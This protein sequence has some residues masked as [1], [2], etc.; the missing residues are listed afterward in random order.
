MRLARRAGCREEGGAPLTT[1]STSLIHCVWVWVYVRERERL[2]ATPCVC[3][4]SVGA[5]CIFYYNTII[6]HTDLLE[7]ALVEGTHC[8]VVSQGEIGGLQLECTL[9]RVLC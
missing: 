3:V 2:Y 7:V 4:L 1:P 5:C 6:V 9:E 8:N